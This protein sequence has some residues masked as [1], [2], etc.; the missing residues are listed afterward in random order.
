MIQEKSIVKFTEKAI[1]ATPK[2]KNVTF[3]VKS[4]DD[5][6][7]TIE[8]ISN[9]PMKTFR[10]NV[11]TISR[12]LTREE[13]KIPAI[14]E[15]IKEVCGIDESQLGR[16]I[17]SSYVRRENK[18]LSKILSGTVYTDKLLLAKSD[19]IKKDGLKGMTYR[20]QIESLEPIA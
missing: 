7:A 11:T 6:V 12:R 2:M 3:I 14:R 18:E 19:K 5:R 9:K 16:A 1:K 13:L 15:E 20:I 10:D 8:V 4:L 17:H